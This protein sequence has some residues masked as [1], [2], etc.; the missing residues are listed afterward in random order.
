[1]KEC[2]TVSRPAKGLARLRTSPL[3]HVLILALDVAIAAA[4]LWG[5][6]LLRFDGRILAE[7]ADRIAE[8]LAL[9]ITVR[10]LSNVVL[11]L[12]RWS[13]RFSGLAD[14]TR[15]GVAGLLGTGLFLVGAFLMQ[16]RMPPRSVVVMEL[17]LT[18]CA[19][20]VLR[21]SPRLAWMYRADRRRVRKNGTL[22]T[23]IVGAGV[24]G[25]MLRRD[26]VQSDEHNYRVIGFVDDDRSKWGAIIGGIPVLG[27]IEGLPRF[28]KQ[29]E[30]GTILIAIPRLAGSRIREI[31]ALCAD[32]KVR[33]K[34]LPVSFVYLRD[35]TSTSMLQDL[36][37]EDLLPREQVTFSN[38]G[39]SALLTG[40]TALVTGAAG[41]IGSEIC[42]Q[43]AHGGIG[44]LAMVDIDE[45]GLYL[46]A[47]KLEREA[48]LVPV[49]LEVADIRDRER[50]VR[51]LA[52]IRPSDVFH[53]AAHKHVPLMEIA[54]GEAVK[55][56]VVA[57]RN[58]ALAAHDNGVERFVYISTDKAVRPTSVMGASKRVGEMIVRS[59]AARSTTRFTAVRFGNVLGSAGSVVPLFREQIVAGGPVTVTHP[60]VRRYFMTIREAVGLVL[61][62]GYGD[63]GALC[64]LDMGEQI[65]IVDLARHMI[66]MAGLLPDEDI[67]ITFIGLRPGE[68]L[69]EEVLTEDEERTVRVSEKILGV[70][71]PRPP[72]DL[73][74]RVDEL[75]TAADAGDV[76]RV[77]SLLRVV[78]P[79]YTTPEGGSP[80]P[81]PAPSSQASDR[82]MGLGK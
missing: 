40:R 79:S 72:G 64:V 69:F 32:L 39:A 49:N 65:K 47:R 62:V 9:L 60:D 4:S 45:N 56:N 34:I 41:S 21:F 53:A 2:W 73:D 46:L 78:V 7:Y 82:A 74:L 71:S 15:I 58:L 57:T 30:I 61:K 31:L 68:K 52:T 76:A 44:R 35:R 42:L 1:M 70:T 75:A 51:L 25:D 12:H 11:K 67:P 5:A 50:M 28:V 80:A 6:L 19:M 48:P 20:T 55:N 77:V 23:L 13:F 24:A 18:T 10:T 17:L 16:V 59:L 43:L 26:L 22:R 37:P 66:T 27:G 14:G 33:F 29:H 36:S 3:R 63:Y 54:P 38:S 81:R 8:Y